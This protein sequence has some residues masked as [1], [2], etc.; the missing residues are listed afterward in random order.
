MARKKISE[1]TEL[2]NFDDL[3]VSEAN[4]EAEELE[5]SEEA[6][7][8]EEESPAKPAKKSRAK[9]KEPEGLA[10]QLLKNSSDVKPEPALP[11]RSKKSEAKE[12]APEEIEAVVETIDVQAEEVSEEEEAPAKK[13][14]RPRSSPE[15]KGLSVAMESALEAMSSHWTKAK[16]AT[17]ALVS[18]L[19]RVKKDLEEVK[20]SSAEPLQ[21]LVNQTKEKQAVA[22]RVTFALSLAAMI[23]SFV[24]LTLSQSVRGQLLGLAQ[25]APVHR[26]SVA[27]NVPAPVRPAARENAP[28]AYQPPQ[29]R[30]AQAAVPSAPA[31]NPI[32][33]APKSLARLPRK[34]APHIH[35]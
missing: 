2:L 23:F 22:S 18:N 16:E 11:S 24:S 25:S 35:R 34:A 8:E 15:E 26:E 4:E 3:D 9:K 33:V 27:Q 20:Q 30:E 13:A 12:E 31:V 19:E 6:E 7:S 5:L 17:D 14:R 1:D 29:R 28:V 21:M 32:P 10:A